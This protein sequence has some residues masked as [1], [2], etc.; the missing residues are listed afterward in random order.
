MEWGNSTPPSQQ[1]IL[2][3]CLSFAFSLT[4]SYLKTT[5]QQGEESYEFLRGIP[6]SACLRG[7]SQ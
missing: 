2:R 7:Q 6:N 5:V 3:Y 4:F 1:Y